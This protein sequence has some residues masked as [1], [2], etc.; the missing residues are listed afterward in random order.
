MLQQDS[1]TQAAATLQS[2]DTAHI[3]PAPRTPYK[4][5]RQLP[6]DATLAQQ[7]S[8]IQ[9][10]F[11]PAEIHWSNRPDTLHLPG[12]D[13]GHNMQEVEIPQ[14]SRTEF[15][16]KDTLFSHEVERAR[17]GCRKGMRL[18]CRGTRSAPGDGIPS[19]HS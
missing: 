15:F 3:S 10:A 14:Y 1:I 18:A 19:R 5:L 9:A 13:A 8:A 16:S 7:D 2:A 12:H 6:R 4:V 11:Q 17:L